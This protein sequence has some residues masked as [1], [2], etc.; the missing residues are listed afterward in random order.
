M[1]EGNGP[2]RL[3]WTTRNDSDF[4]KGI[5]IFHIDF[6]S[7]QKFSWRAQLET[8]AI[9]HFFV[10]IKIFQVHNNLSFVLMWNQSS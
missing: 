9:M 3:Q 6:V 4:G 8:D 7:F 1:L 2:K 5:L 10:P